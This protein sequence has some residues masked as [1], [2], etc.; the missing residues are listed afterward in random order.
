[1]NTLSAFELIMRDGHVLGLSHRSELADLLDQPCPVYVL[2]ELAAGSA[3]DL[4]HVLETCLEDAGDLLIDGTIAAS[5]A[6]ADRL[7][8]CHEAMVES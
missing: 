7:W 1:M 8:S 3:V 6:Q 2:M 4:R 5:R